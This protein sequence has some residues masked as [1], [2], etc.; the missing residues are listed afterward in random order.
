MIGPIANA[1]TNPGAARLVVNRFALPAPSILSGTG[2][3]SGTDHIRA[4]MFCR[5]SNMGRR[6][7]MFSRGCGR[8]MHFIKQKIVCADARHQHQHFRR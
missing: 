6:R 8:R 4:D 2:P 1:Q 3:A 7:M 5:G